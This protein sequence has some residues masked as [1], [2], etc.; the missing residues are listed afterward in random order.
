MRSASCGTMVTTVFSRWKICVALAH[1]MGARAMSTVSIPEASQRLRQFSRLGENG[2]F[3]G[4]VDGHET[5]YT[6]ADLR[7][8]C[9]CA[10]CVAGARETNHRRARV[11]EMPALSNTS[12]K[13]H[14]SG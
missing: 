11:A 10:Y 9:R 6:A 13:S 1:A 4:W 5:L 12:I 14:Y 2:V 7:S 3:I 8:L